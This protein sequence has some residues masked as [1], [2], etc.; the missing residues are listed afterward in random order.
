MTT[1]HR[2]LIAALILTVGL[3]A[4]ACSSSSGSRN[5]AGA[6]ASL[7]ESDLNEFCAPPRDNDGKSG[8]ATVRNIVTC[9]VF[10]NEA[11]KFSAPNTLGAKVP[12]T[13]TK[14]LCSSGT[15]SP[16]VYNSGYYGTIRD[17]G[18]GSVYGNRVLT[19]NPFTG[20]AAIQFMPNKIWQGTENRVLVNSSDAPFTLQQTAAQP[21]FE[22]PSSGTN[23]GDCDTQGS[24][25]GCS[26]DNGSWQRNGTEQRPRYTFFTKPMRITISNSLG[27][28]MSLQSPASAGR[29]FLLDPVAQ[30]GV[31]SI[32]PGAQ[33]FVGG[34]R[35]TNSADEQSWTAS[36]CVE[37]KSPTAGPKCVPVDITVKVAW[38]EADK[39]W[40]N[41]SQCSVQNREQGFTAKCDTPTMN[42][43]DTDRIVSVNIKNF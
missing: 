24:F 42:D 15:T 41:Q 19:P 36:Y 10:V 18:T 21:Y 11:K 7:S 29:G 32:A 27:F 26:I 28:P 16:C 43:S 1:R 2:A 25:I 34:Y 17:E 4:G 31:S 23:G 20:L 37:W 39:K 14:A 9:F 35:S 22:N 5:A 33:A 38:V 12:L 6:S 13:V 3:V 40:V 8:F 30:G